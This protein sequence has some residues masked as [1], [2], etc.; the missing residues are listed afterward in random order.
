MNTFVSGNENFRWK[1][2]RWVA[3][4]VAASAR[5][6][7]GETIKCIHAH[8]HQSSSRQSN[9]LITRRKKAGFGSRQ[10]NIWAR[11]GE[12]LGCTVHP[13]AL[14]SLLLVNVTEIATRLILHSAQMV[15]GP[16]EGDLNGFADGW[17]AAL[18]H[19]DLVNG[20]VHSERNH[21]GFRKP[22]PI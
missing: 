15:H 5:H 3:V 2:R 18:H 1:W 14:W 21:F 10:L 17:G 12:Y 22:L 20:F 11:H 4:K 6:S 8:S 16:R 19:F 13:C 9:F 7:E